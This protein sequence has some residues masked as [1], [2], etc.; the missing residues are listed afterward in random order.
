MGRPR[1]NPDAPGARRKSPVTVVVR[2][3][4]TMQL[5]I[6]MKDVQIR[7]TLSYNEARELGEKLKFA[8]GRPLAASVGNITS[9]DSAKP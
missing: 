7:L 9:I 8:A 1:K 2:S 6:E 3:D 4:N 5:E